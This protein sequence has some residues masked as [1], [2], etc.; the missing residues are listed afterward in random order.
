MEIVGKGENSGKE[1]HSKAG[2][3]VNDQERMSIK[4]CHPFFDTRVGCLIQE[5]QEH[6]IQKRDE[7]ERPLRLGL[8]SSLIVFC[9]T[10]YML[11]SLRNLLFPLIIAI[12]I[13]GFFLFR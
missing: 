10:L 7:D 12:L 6:E 4:L 8:W 3:V 13:I 5:S 9:S 1:C 2:I 11:F